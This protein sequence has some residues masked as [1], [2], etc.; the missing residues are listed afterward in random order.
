MDNAELK[1]RMK[2]FNEIEDEIARLKALAET[3]NVNYAD[4]YNGQNN[5]TKTN[6]NAVV[7]AGAIVV[8][9]LSVLSVAAGIVAGILLF[10]FIFIINTTVKDLRAEATTTLA[11]I[12]QLRSEQNNLGV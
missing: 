8:A 11:R 12:D 10:G 2:R 7:F 9:I 5:K 3:Q 4:A 1:I 6:T